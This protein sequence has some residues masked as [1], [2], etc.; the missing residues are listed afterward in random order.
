MEWVLLLVILGRSEA[1]PASATTPL[2]LGNSPHV[3]LIRFQGP[4]SKGALR[5]SRE[6]AD[7]LR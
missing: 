7:G 2:T 3:E 4:Q 5:R 6:A 1:P